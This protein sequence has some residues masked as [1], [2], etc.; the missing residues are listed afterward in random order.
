MLKAILSSAVLALS[1]VNFAYAADVS[2]F[3]N[4]RLSPN[5]SQDIWQNIRK[6]EQSLYEND[7]AQAGKLIRKTRKLLKSRADNNEDFNRVLTVL[8]CE[9]SRLRG[10][11]SCNIP[12]ILK[13]WPDNNDEIFNKYKALAHINNFSYRRVGFE[14]IVE[15]YNLTAS[16]PESDVLKKRVTAR[17]ID[18][19]V[20]PP[21]KRPR[22]Q[23]D[24]DEICEAAKADLDFKFKWA[25]STYEGRDVYNGCSSDEGYIIADFVAV[26]DETG[27]PAVEVD[28]FDACPPNMPREATSK[29][30][31]FHSENE[32][33]IIKEL[34]DKD[35]VRAY[36]EIDFIRLSSFN[37]IND[38]P[39]NDRLRPVNR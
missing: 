23:N 21:A 28:V 2:S 13:N 6:I 26:H 37:P 20:N 24:I 38:V 32:A 27:Q 16:L 5:F 35:R 3:D 36:F 17:V 7:T 8:N 4:S 9:N 39:S 14:D 18:T 29:K 25:I 1:A 34:S 31:N 33:K 19:C 11:R 30:T 15:A 10:T 12:R 22:P